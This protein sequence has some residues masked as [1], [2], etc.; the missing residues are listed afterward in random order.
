[1]RKNLILQIM[2]LL[3]MGL[4]V[5]ESYGIPAFA[6]RYKISCTTCH[7]PFP[8][9]KPYGNDFAG[10]GM[11]IKEEERDRDY[12]SAGDDLLWLNRDFPVAVRF[13]AYTV[14]D[15]NHKVKKDLQMP[16]G[17]KLMSG[18]TLY[19]NIGYYFYFYMSERG[20]V[21]GIEDGYIHF[22]NL[23]SSGLDIMVGQFQTSDPLMKREL[24]LTFEDYE[25]YKQSIGKSETNLTY[26]RGI[27]LVYGIEKT[28]TDLV[29]MIVNGNGKEEAGD[30][31]K[32]DM[33][34]HKNI[35]LR[36]MQDVMGWF[37]IGGFY[38]VGKEESNGIIN[39]VT[40]VGPD[41]NT[42]IGPLDLTFQ[43]LLRKD[44]DPMFISRPDIKVETEGIVCEVTFSPKLDKSRFYLTGLYNHIE[45]D[46]NCGGLDVMDYETATLSGTYLLARNLRVSV[47]YTRDL[48]IDRN[49]FVLGLVSGF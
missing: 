10:N 47:E 24:R 22:D 27:M 2:L 4:Y 40:Y 30:D 9:L 19:K 1:M 13:D 46:Y 14:S 23:F 43:Y 37:N 25:I 36:L 39:K 7:T 32:F 44:T 5:Q 6:R 20:G 41:F 35:G 42:S 29:G 38:Y 33:D 28:G 18:G 31:K 26:D 48:H 12:I 15:E 21:E 49:R 11:V 16:W 34:N 45:Y 8:R 17:L 3:F